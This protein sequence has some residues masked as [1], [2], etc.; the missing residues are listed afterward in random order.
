MWTVYL[1]NNQILTEKDCNWKLLPNYPI[2][3]LEW[4][5]PNGRTVVMTGFESYLAMHEDYHIFYGLIKNK[6][7][8]DTVNLFGKKDNQVFQFS[9]SLRFNKAYQ[10]KN[11]WNK[12]FRPLQLSPIP[13]INKKEP[14]RFSIDFGSPSKTNHSLWHEGVCLPTASSKII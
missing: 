4:K 3:K 7:V 5:I 6:V 10:I 2:V 9:Y 14:K 11:E 13:R 1:I 8:K 12:E